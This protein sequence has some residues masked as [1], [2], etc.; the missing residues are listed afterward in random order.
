MNKEIEIKIGDKT[1]PYVELFYNDSA[2]KASYEAF[3]S[4]TNKIE[5]LRNQINANLTKM[6]EKA[7]VS[8]LNECGFFFKN[9]KEIEE[10]LVL[11]CGAESY[12]NGFRIYIDN[13]PVGEIE[14]VIQVNNS[15]YKH[16]ILGGINV[17][18][19]I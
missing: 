14:D 7:L 17:K 10:F 4:E 6:K 9:R 11:R 1:I 18:M 5:L 2:S 16:E 3:K 8:I 19:F 12:P 13:T 15:E